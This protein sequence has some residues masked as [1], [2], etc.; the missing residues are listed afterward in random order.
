V[1]EGA[2]TL[3]SS[4]ARRA[5]TVT[6]SAL[7]RSLEQGRLDVMAAY[8]RVLLEGLALDASVDPSEDLETQL[9]AT[10]LAFSALAVLRSWLASGGAF[11]LRE[12]AVAAVDLAYERFSVS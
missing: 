5:R 4:T 1:E 6:I 7:R 11:D 10:T 3:T 2:G 12:R 8:E 9:L